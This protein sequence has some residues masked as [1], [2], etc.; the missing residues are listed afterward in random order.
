MRSL[1]T[2]EAVPKGTAS[3]LLPHLVDELMEVS[4]MFA[5][6]SSSD[7]PETVFLSGIGSENLDV[8]VASIMETGFD[9]QILLEA[10]MRNWDTFVQNMFRY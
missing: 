3:L 8:Q 5:E 1:K 2:A 10:T 6:Q 4:A 9:R 7:I